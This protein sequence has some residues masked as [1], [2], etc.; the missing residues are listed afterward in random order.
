VKRRRK[1]GIYGRRLLLSAIGASLHGNP[2]L[3][4]QEIEGFPPCISDKL[5][6]L[7]VI[8]FDLNADESQFAIQ[9]INSHPELR[10]I[11]VDLANNE[12]LVLSG[13]KCRLLNKED[14][15]QAIEGGGSV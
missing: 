4:V 10:T 12:M 8:L 7:D 2:A 13:N 3:E 5:D 11:G 1:V 9:L 15:A 6:A 14:L